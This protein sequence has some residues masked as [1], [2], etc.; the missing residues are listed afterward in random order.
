MSLAY[1]ILAAHEENGTVTVQFENQRP[2]N[3]SV[4]CV[5]G[6]F[7]TGERLEGWIQGLNGQNRWDG[8][9][10]VTGWD[11]I[12]GLVTDGIALSMPP[13]P[14]MPGASTGTV[15]TEGVTTV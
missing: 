3:I 2:Y 9:S 12:A 8:V 10:T 15:T 4:P 6:A 5:D 7:L 1:K 14:M 11:S 13:S